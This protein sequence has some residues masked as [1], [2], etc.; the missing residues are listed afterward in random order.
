MCFEGI[1]VRER[2]GVGKLV[3]PGQHGKLKLAAFQQIH[4]HNF[5]GMRSTFSF[6]RLTEM[7]FLPYLIRSISRESPQ[8]CL[9]SYCNVSLVVHISFLTFKRNI[10]AT[11][12]LIPSSLRVISAVAL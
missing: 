6:F 9:R 4:H 5:L 11:A 10:V 7:T 12:F 1:G 2:G 8:E 3:I